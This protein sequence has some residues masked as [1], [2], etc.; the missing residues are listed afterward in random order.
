MFWRRKRSLRDL[1]AEIESHVAHEADQFQVGGKTRADAEAAA[2]QAFGNVTSLQEAFYQH[3]RW[4]LWDQVSL[5]LRHA[6]RLFWRRPGFSA[7]VV[8]T[9][10]LG[11]GANTAIFSVINAVLLRPLPYRDPSRLAMLW[12][13]DSAHDVQE[14]RVSL[15]N[16]A[17]WK[18]RSHTFEGMTLFI[19]Q[20]FLLGSKDGPPERMRSA[21]VSWNFFPL[22]GV[23]PILG[24]V[25]TAEEE[26]RGES[27]VVL[28]YG[29]W[30][31]RFGGSGQVLGSDLIMDKRKA[32]I[33]G[34][35]PASFQYPF[36][37]TQVWEPVT[38]HPYWAARDRTS[39]RSSSNW[40]A[41]GRI[42]PGAAWAEVQSE[43]SGIA[44]QL[45]LEY[46]ESRN[47]PDIGV[48]PL[49]AQTTGR[50]QR[51]LTVL[52]G[53][54]LLM[55][56]IACMNVANLL[57]ARGS[58]RERE[59]SLRRALGAGRSR[60]AAQLLTE[61][62]V[63]S[64]AGGSLGLA[65]AAA[66][67]RALI[68]FGPR[69][70]PRLDEARID[71][72]VLLFTLSLSLLAAIVSGL[73][74]AMR[75]GATPARSRQWSTVA[76]RSVRNL[77]VVGEFSIALI[78][79]AGAGL[80]V[81]SFVRLHS[82]EPGFRPEKLLVMRIDLHI[83]RTA[84]QYVAYFRDAIEQVQAL[85]G[86]RSAAA[87]EGFLRSDPEDAVEIE[88]RAPQQPGPCEDAIE[89]PLFE[90]AGIPLKRGR[91]FS[92]ED[93][94]G[95]PPVAIVNEAMARAY[96]P[97]EEAIGKRF[98]FPGAG[99]QPWM[100]VVGVTGDMHRQGLEKRVV[101]Q[102]FRPLAQDPGDMLEVIVRTS[103]DA[104]AMAAAVRN[105][106]QS[107][108]K[109]VAKFDVTTVEQ[110]LG[111]Q[112][113]ERRFQTSLIALFSLVALLLSAIGI[114]GLMHYFVAQRTNEIG[115]RMALG[116]HYGSVLALVLRQGLTLAGL[117]IVVGIAG[118]LGLTRLLSSLLYGTTPTDALTFAAAPT[119]LLGVAGLACWIPARRA[120]RIDPMLAL[121][122]E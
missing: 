48:I 65:L 46:P 10:A 17:D 89:G 31:D 57:L 121:R 63:L 113:A 7:V 51:P 13:K 9:L 2:R 41:L 56:L 115:V 64:A 122:Q 27:V 83:G 40:Y 91:V 52:F 96:W 88:G 110:Q 18:N 79:L 61:S 54:V 80:M 1:A 71:P 15:L 32:R 74:P 97:N 39:P 67:L 85:P 100:T 49:Q 105:E 45:A 12:S 77:L 98:R 30:Q 76:D 109:S 87:I 4:L 101:P 14:G 103:A 5:D 112:T 6:L 62:L 66:A 29:L 111:E 44:R 59:F 116:A 84:A 95:S 92:D 11:I 21:R 36:T 70:I 94:A 108:D 60:L 8:L 25:F 102:I 118:A 38:A 86:V 58:A 37:D 68:A 3:G 119:I 20:T 82:V 106:I 120:A 47:L 16:F 50:V 114:Y 72:H 99:S 33:I 26:R 22:L 43:M 19:G 69:E 35:M 23:E 81:R 42:R 117:G 55:L 107:L 73:W 24:R 75:S 78:L 104:G 53:S 28:S 34:V 93:R 90:T